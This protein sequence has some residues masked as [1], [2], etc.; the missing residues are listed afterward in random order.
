MASEVMLTIPGLQKPRRCHKTHLPKN[1]HAFLN[2]NVV[3]GDSCAVEKH[4]A[5]MRS[6]SCQL[7][8]LK[9][10]ISEAYIGHVICFLEIWD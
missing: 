8:L 1:A 4:Q 3:V 9:A 6:I 2:I 7:R 5:M 10:N